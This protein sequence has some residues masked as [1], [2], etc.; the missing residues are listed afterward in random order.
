M[1]HE[2]GSGAPQE[3]SGTVLRDPDQTRRARLAVT[4][5]RRAL[6]ANPDAPQLLPDTDLAA[7]AAEFERMRG[8]LSDS[9]RR[10]ADLVEAVPH[11]DPVALTGPYWYGQG[12]D[13]AVD[14]L[15]LLADGMET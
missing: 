13:C 14:Y 3:R 8:L 15:R 6:A 12:W 2:T 4:R 10:A 1:P 11:H 5:I 7:L 9:W